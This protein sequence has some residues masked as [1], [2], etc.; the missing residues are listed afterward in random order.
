M[1][2]GR[3]E[4]Q[5]KHEKVL[6]TGIKRTEHQEHQEHQEGKIQSKIKVTDM[7]IATVAQV[8]HHIL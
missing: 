4:P 3:R 2:R 5:L 6:R 7:R 8:M 1:G